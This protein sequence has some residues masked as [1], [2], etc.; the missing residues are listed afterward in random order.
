MR[1]GKKGRHYGKKERAAASA[2]TP[3]TQGIFSMKPKAMAGFSLKTT[4]FAPR[5]RPRRC[6]TP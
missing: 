6:F 4:P 5:R 2:A 3:S 1:S